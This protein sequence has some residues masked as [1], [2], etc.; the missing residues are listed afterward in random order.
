MCQFCEEMGDTGTHV[1]PD[2]ES[3]KQTPEGEGGGERHHIHKQPLWFKGLH[4]FTETSQRPRELSAV[5]SPPN[6]DPRFRELK[7]LPQSPTGKA[8]STEISLTPRPIVVSQHMLFAQRRGKGKPAF[9]SY[10]DLRG[11][12]PNVNS[13]LTQVHEPAFIP[14]QGLVLGD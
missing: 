7:A 6:K 2:A 3:R 12:Y 5:S 1:H 9:S 10:R 8:K 11:Q 14:G 13:H 4:Y